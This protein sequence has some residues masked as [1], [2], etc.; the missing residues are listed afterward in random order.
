MQYRET[1]FNF[2]SRLM[3]EEGI[4]YFFQHEKGKH[5][6]VL[7]DQ[8][9][10]HRLPGKQ[11]DYP[12]DPGKKRKR[13]TSRVGNT[14]MSSAPGKWA[15]TDYNFEDHPARGA[16]LPADLMMTKESTTVDLPDVKKYEFYDYP[17]TYARRMTA[18]ATPSCG[19]RK[20]RS[21]TTWSTPGATAAPFFRAG[22][23]RSGSTSR[24]AERGKGYVIT[25]LAHSAT[26][27]YETGDE[28]SEFDYRNSF[29]CIPDAVV[30]RPA[31]TTP[32][33]MIHGVQ[34]AVVTG[35]GRGDLSRQVRPREGAVLL[36][37]RGQAR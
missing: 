7:A 6:L 17:G 12:R 36:G 21:S 29:T 1:D 30:F 23:S 37:P 8:K 15:Q 5:T 13:T 26:E 25:A 9:S 22:S 27:G 4:F 3:E 16:P 14:I 18:P 32:K 11:V 35:A 24:D 19:W 28:G 31:R 2:V 20:R 33:P 10:L 34:P